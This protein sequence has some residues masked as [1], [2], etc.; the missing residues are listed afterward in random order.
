MA[1]Y[2]A[3]FLLPA[4]HPAVAIPYDSAGWW[5]WFAFVP[6][7]MH[8]AFFLTPPRVNWKTWIGAALGLML[9]SLLIFTG[10]NRAA[11]LFVA[12]QSL[13]FVTTI[14]V[15]RARGVGRPL[16]IFEML[17][18]GFL[19][20]KLLGFSRASESFAQASS[21]STQVILG[22]C[23]GAVFL[24]SFIL[25]LST[26]GEG[27]RRKGKKEV[28]IFLT[29]AA[30]VGLAAAFLMPSDFINHNVVLNELKNPPEP[31][32]IT[33]DDYSDG[34][35]GGNLRSRRPQDSDGNN[36]AEGAGEE[37]SGDSEGEEG[38]N[39]LEG[40]PA[41]QWDSR[42]G[43]SQQ[44]SQGE[45]EGQGTGEGEGEGEGKQYAVMVVASRDDP[46]Y[47]AEAYYSDFDEIRGFLYAQEEPLNDLTHLRLIETWNNTSPSDDD[48]RSE[49]EVFF[50]STIPD[51]VL[52]Y[53][54][55]S[56]QPTILNK[57]YHPF[58]FSYAAL[59]GI[60][61][62]NPRNWDQIIGLNSF[63]QEN[64]SEFLEVSLPEDIRDSII[65]FY[66]TI[67]AG[68]EGYY[69]RLEAIIKA[70]S[71]YQY[72]I[73]F[74]DDVSL[75]HISDFLFNTKSGD[76][77]EFSNSTAILARLAGIP[78]R[79]VTGY[80][81]SRGLQTQAHMRGLLVLQEI[82]EPLQQFS[83]DELYLVTN[84]H[85]HSWVQ[86]FMPGYGWVDVETTATAIPPVGGMNPN[87]MDVVIPIIQPGD[88]AQP[89][90]A[91]PWLLALQALGILLVA[92]LAG[93]YIFR[94]SRRLYLKSLA[95]GESDR[96]LKALH[97][98]LLTGLANEGYPIKR[99]SETPLE[100]AQEHPEMR[101]FAEYFT[102]LRFKDR[103]AEGEKKAN[104]NQLRFSYD[105]T[106]DSAKK[107]GLWG[108]LRRVFSLRDLRY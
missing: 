18:L 61:Q 34:L 51:R 62:S 47:A 8:L 97:L 45:G 30:V 63:E 55:L 75:A 94:F 87:E 50:L 92:G 70:Y 23:L 46:I 68:K 80:L 7:Q 5:L 48:K 95:R 79:V 65:T 100:Y 107:R 54:P 88:V 98:L 90:F 43:G 32:Y 22:L 31:D 39:R 84:M 49:T 96:S 24:H 28:G 27:L 38:T 19:Y 35:E 6:L 25:Y 53:E 60:S 66:D 99:D 13:A 103:F 10:F 58:D 77:T 57:V 82:I 44:S 11:F 52:A 72:N 105:E 17:F 81:A 78:S 76:C 42:R 86:V 26:F 14:L 106:L 20:I 101:N 59:S 15:F 9:V 37:N 2:L 93:A 29:I 91:F 73:G 83:L 89:R 74:T 85:R 21:A 102:Q 67:T 1:L 40:I 71:T 64:L 56:V 36:G 33:L 104:W 3:A 69:E 4:L 108:F 12:A 41:D 16:A